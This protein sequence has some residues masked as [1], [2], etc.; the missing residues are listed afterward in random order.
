M[1]TPSFLPLYTQVKELM[2][3]RITDS[4]WLPGMLLPSENE[5]AKELKVSQGTVR[6][7]LDEMALDKLVV[8]KQGRGTY[9]TEH[10]NQRDLFHFFHLVNSKGVG[11][12]LPESHVITI[13]EGVCT[14]QELELL[15]LQP[16]DEVIRVSRV[17]LLENKPVIYELISVPKSLFPYLSETEANLP[18]SL[19]SLYESRYGVSV[20]R[21]SEWLSARGA[22]QYTSEQL[23]IENGAP[24]LTIRRLA[25]TLSHRPVELRVSHCNTE[26]HHYLSELI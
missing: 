26:N 3:K 18:N 16:T 11:K 25:Y 14:Q 8:R 4:L 12:N 5:L 21:A 20:A 10:D 7:A 6:K 15:E 1:D 2:I 13:E 23:K 22:N 19:Y 24:I 9:I 17:R